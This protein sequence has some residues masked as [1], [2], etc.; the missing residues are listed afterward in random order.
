MKRFFAKNKI[1]F[2]AV[3]GGLALAG[4]TFAG[5]NAR[6][7]FVQYLAFFAL[8]PLLILMLKNR[9]DKR[10]ARKFYWLGWAFFAAWL[11]PTT[12][13][14]FNFMPLWL[15]PLASFGFAFLMANLF[16]IFKIKKLP[17]FAVLLIFAAVWA[18]WTFARLHLPI[19]ADWWLPHLGYAVWRLPAA[20]FF[21]KLGGAANVEFL[22]LLVNILTAILWLKFCRKTL[23][24][25]GGFLLI[26]VGANFI[27]NN[28]PAQN[29]ANVAAV[30][31]TGE[32][33]QLSQLTHA[34]KQEATSESLTVVWPE[35]H[36][37]ANGLA[38]ARALA[39]ELKI[40]LVVNAADA[41]NRN[42]EILLDANGREILTNYK[43]HIA[44]GENHAAK[45]SANSVKLGGEKV[46]VF[47][48]YDLHYPDIVGRIGGAKTVFASVNDSD[49][50]RLEQTFHLA[51]SAFDA[52][53]SGANIAVSSSNGKTAFVDK[54]GRVAAE[55]PV[56][57]EGVLLP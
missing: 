14:Y 43:F 31:T 32:F 25:T 38:Q 46:A 35:N 23:Y 36:L 20:T 42:A 21:A 3:G 53:Q 9:A 26:F 41:Q 10:F 33:T 27:I 29:F 11:A 13:W 22:V 45:W 52:V 55:L 18:V 1:W 47:I 50:G 51:D 4:A 56:N 40:N 54:F 48:C 15:A 6:L 30:Q 8:V 57:T 37:S 49:F 19:V 12:Y 7:F 28:F 44:P 34:A 39:Q 16:C 5:E 2:V 24:F 17:N